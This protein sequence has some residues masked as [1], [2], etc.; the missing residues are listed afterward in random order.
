MTKLEKRNHS[1]V[2]RTRIQEAILSII[3]SGGRVGGDKLIKQVVDGLIG[4]DLSSGPTR[5]REVVKSA[6]SRLRMKGLIDFKDGRYLPTARGEEL[7]ETWQMN[8][9]RIKKPKKW[10]NK[11]RVVVFD[12]PEKKRA[13]RDQVREILVM[14]G[15]RRLQN[16]VWIYPY[17]C[18]DVIGLL[19]AKMGIG[20]N[21][22]YM[23]VDQVE[24]DR[25]LRMDFDLIK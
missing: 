11:W 12:I 7:F 4:T 10:D 14:A 25:S 8:E 16:S 13:T 23:I 6:A 20:R 18:E 15:F 9:Y 19:K 2:R 17:D 24:N 5:Q 22:L 3:I 21:L 1:R